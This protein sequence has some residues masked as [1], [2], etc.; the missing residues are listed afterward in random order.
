MPRS[1]P[2]NPYL[3]KKEIT[4]SVLLAVRSASLPRSRTFDI[5]RRLTTVPF[6]AQAVS[7]WYRRFV[8]AVLFPWRSQLKDQQMLV[9]RHVDI[10]LVK[11]TICMQPELDEFQ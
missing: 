8:Q 5:S 10:L 3:S 9:L 2:K 1:Q 4:C 7:H 11:T 6:I